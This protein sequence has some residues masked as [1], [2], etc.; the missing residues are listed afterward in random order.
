VSLYH[1]RLV[2]DCPLIV[3]YWNWNMFPVICSL[4]I[5]IPLIVPYWNWNYLIADPKAINATFNRTILELK[6]RNPYPKHQWCSPFNRTILELKLGQIF[7]IEGVSFTFN[8]TIL[9]LKRNGSRSGRGSRKPLIVPYWNWNLSHLLRSLSPLSF[10]RT[11]LELKHPCN[12]LLLPV[13]SCL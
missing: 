3:P 4:Y 2:S 13:F 10:N 1:N 9:E 12:S 5:V 7:H 11:I 6:Q 8:R